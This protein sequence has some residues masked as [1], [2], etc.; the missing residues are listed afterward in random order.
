MSQLKQSIEGLIEAIKQ[1]P[2]TGKATFETTTVL[3]EG[4]RVETQIRDFIL[5]ADEPEVTGGADSA[6]NPLEY[7]AASL[8]ACQAI[9]YR[10]VATLKG[11]SLN[12]LEVKV[13]AYTDLNGFLAID[14]RIRPGFLKVEFETVI[15]SDEK[16]AKL[17]ALAEA[18]E[19]LCPVLDIFANK[20]PVKGKLIIEKA[21]ELV[22]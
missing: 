3:K 9:T 14:N 7:L 10:A 6:P 4:V 19:A 17:K 5:R 2:E 15:D 8:G 12:G 18:V 21:K 20:T 16:P 1:N 11:I 13:K 22:A